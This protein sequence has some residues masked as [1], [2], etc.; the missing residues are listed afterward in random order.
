MRCLLARDEVG[1]PGL[2]ADLPRRAAMHGR[3]VPSTPTY[4]PMGEASDQQ[5]TQNPRTGRYRVN[6]ETKQLGIVAA[7][8]VVAMVVLGVG[9]FKCDQVRQAAIVEC[10]KA[11]KAPLECKEAIGR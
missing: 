4:R 8:L 6:D 5:A 9:G 10:V 1:N 2:Q 11:G 3:R 7:F